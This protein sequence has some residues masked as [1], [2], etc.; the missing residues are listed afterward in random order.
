MNSLE[1]AVELVVRWPARQQAQRMEVANRLDAVIKDCRAARDIWQGY[2]DSP[3]APGDR[4]ALVSWIG[5][6]RAKRLHEINLGAKGRL[7]TVA[8]A[9]GPEAGRFILFEEDVIEMAYRQLP[10]GETGPDAA[11]AS[12][13]VMNERIKLLGDWVQRLRSAKP[14]ATKAASEAAKKKTAKKPIHA[15]PAATKKKAKPKPAPKKK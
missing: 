10:D 12:I 3:G 6:E 4:W 14:L 7:K 1:K 8:D 15:K 13:A 2:L 5:P 9:A 11:K